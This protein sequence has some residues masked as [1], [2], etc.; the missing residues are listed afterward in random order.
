VDDHTNILQ[1]NCLPEI[2]FIIPTYND[3]E[4]VLDTIDNIRLLT[5]RHKNILIIN[6]GSTDNTFELLS[7]NLKLSPVPIYFHEKL[8]TKKV[9]GVYVSSIYPEITVIDKE[10]G[11]KFDA[12]NVA[13][14]ACKTAYFSIVDS[15]TFIDDVEFESLIRPIFAD[16]DTIA[17]GAAI[18]IANECDLIENRV[19]TSK[20]P[21][22]FLV[23]VQAVEYMRS[24]LM[25]TGWEGIRNNYIIS[26][27]FG[28]FIRDVVIQA[29]GYAPTV[30]NDLEI[31]LRL[32]RIMRATKTPFKIVY[33]PDPVAWTKVPA[34]LK[35]LDAQRL[36]WHRGLMESR[37]FYKKNGF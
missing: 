33:R 12:I 25:R 13:L 27:A 19:D 37:W 8:P 34:N 15:D 23:G 26:G 5:Y 9:R 29:G 1:S 4:Y 28:V 11:E 31:T 18:K 17:I 2:T 24:F 20:F 21:Q 35:D 36:R 16:P 30:A 10:N 3:N 32:D 6:D 14:N 22:S 7:K